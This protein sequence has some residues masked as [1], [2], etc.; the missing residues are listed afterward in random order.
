MNNQGVVV[1]ISTEKGDKI[2]D[3]FLWD[4]SLHKLPNGFG[5]TVASAIALNDLGVAVGWASFPGSPSPPA[6]AALWTN[7]TSAMADLGTVDG[8]ADSFAFSIR[9]FSRLL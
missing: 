5:G 8:D 2:Q 1:G 6:H 4:G 3:A 9:A 7:S